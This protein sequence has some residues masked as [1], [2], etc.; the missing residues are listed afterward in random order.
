MEHVFKTIHDVISGPTTHLRNNKLTD[1]TVGQT[2]IYTA[3]LVDVLIIN[4]NTLA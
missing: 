4:Y 2:L 3:T 1:K